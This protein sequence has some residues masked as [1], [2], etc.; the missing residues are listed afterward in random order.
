MSFFF[1]PFDFQPT[2]RSC[3]PPARKLSRFS[4]LAFGISLC[5]LALVLALLPLD[6]LPLPRDGDNEDSSQHR[7]PEGGGTRGRAY[8]NSPVAKSS[9]P[10]WRCDK[11]RKKKPAAVSLS[12]VDQFP[13]SLSPRFSFSLFPPILS[14]APSDA[15]TK[16]TDLRMA[17]ITNVLWTKSSFGGR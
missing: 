16:L 1:S 17:L 11:R 4:S 14:L 12:L 13:R 8:R 10:L 15:S 3:P 9:A 6:S 7:R 5:L 2:S